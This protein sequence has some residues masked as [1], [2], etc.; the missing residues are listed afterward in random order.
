MSEFTSEHTAHN[1]LKAG[2]VSHDRLIL[3]KPLSMMS[4]NNCRSSALEHIPV[5]A[6]DI[7]IIHESTKLE[8]LQKGNL[9]I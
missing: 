1:L 7:Y 4:E 2:S 9:K 3:G 8:G 6:Y 5:G